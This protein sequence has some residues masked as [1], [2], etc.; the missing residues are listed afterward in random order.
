MRATYTASRRK[1]PSQP[2]AV[3]AAGMTS[4]RMMPPTPEKDITMPCTVPRRVANQ[5]LT[6]MD[7]ITAV[8]MA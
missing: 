8:H 2:Q 3:I 7:A 5:V 4:P 6:R 1:P